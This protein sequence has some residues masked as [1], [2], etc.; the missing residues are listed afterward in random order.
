MVIPVRL[1]RVEADRVVRRPRQRSHRPGHLRRGPARR[2][3]GQAAHGASSC[4]GGDDRPRRRL[5]GRLRQRQAGRQAPGRH[6]G[7]GLRPRPP[8]TAAPRAR[9]LR[10]PTRPRTRTGRPGHCRSARCGR[11]RARQPDRGRAA[12]RRGRRSP[13]SAPTGVV[14]LANRGSRP[15]PS[16]WP[17]QASRASA[18][19]GIPAVHYYALFRAGAANDLPSAHQLTTPPGVGDQLK[20]GSSATPTRPTGPF[21]IH[22]GQARAAFG[23][24]SP[25]GVACRPSTTS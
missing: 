3:V 13:R 8:A 20:S 11:H 4:S 22:K 21:E 1:S 24:S 6:P 2:G 9:T 15:A 12:A 10:S 16:P 5:L 18:A 14:F 7:Q 19:T 23:R 25:K 17:C